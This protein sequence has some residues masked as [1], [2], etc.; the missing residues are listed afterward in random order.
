MTTTKNKNKPKLDNEKLIQEASDNLLFFSDSFA[1]NQ[2]IMT[3]NE[4]LEYMRTATSDIIYNLTQ[5][6]R[7]LTNKSGT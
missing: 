4:F 7:D 5:V 1:E 2:A 3:D 6:S